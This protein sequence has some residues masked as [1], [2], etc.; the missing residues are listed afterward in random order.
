[1]AVYA[2]LGIRTDDRVRLAIDVRRRKQIMFGTGFSADPAWDILLRLYAAQL[3]D[4]R[5]SLDGMGGDYPL[6]TLARWSRVLEEDGL[7]ECE[8]DRL[9]PSA[10]WLKLTERGTFKMATVFRGWDNR[11]GLGWC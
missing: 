9:I 2:E 4:E 5:F 11:A 1:M 10:L 8:T 6:S 3:R 7:I